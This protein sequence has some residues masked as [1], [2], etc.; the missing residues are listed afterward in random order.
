MLVTLHRHKALPFLGRALDMYDSHP[1]ETGST[2]VYDLRLLSLTHR[3]TPAD[4]FIL[5]HCFDL[6]KCDYWDPTGCRE[7]PKFCDSRRT[8]CGSS[9]PPVAKV[10]CKTNKF[11]TISATC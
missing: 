4:A 5:L 7:Y 1:A 11:H 8:L 2:G 9:E 6:V 10:S 3:D